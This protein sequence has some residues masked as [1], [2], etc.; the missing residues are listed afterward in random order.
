M[1][2][3]TKI[4]QQDKERTYAIALSEPEAESYRQLLVKSGYSTDDIKIC[5]TPTLEEG[6]NVSEKH[7]ETLQLYFIPY[8]MASNV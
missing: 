6:M 7:K 1:Y 3:F 2:W 4:K 8:Q 5:S